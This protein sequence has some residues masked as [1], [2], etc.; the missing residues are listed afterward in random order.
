MTEFNFNDF[1]I[2]TWEQ[3]DGWH[4]TGFDT[5]ALGPFE[6]EEEAIAASIE[7]A[8]QAGAEESGQFVTYPDC[9]WNQ[10]SEF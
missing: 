8:K 5:R 10:K 7:S 6:S 2:E 3:P 1:P 9:S 4:S